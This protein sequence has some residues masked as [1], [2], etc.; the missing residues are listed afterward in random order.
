MT[1]SAQR[2][3]GLGV[4]ALV[5][6]LII[7]NLTRG[8]EWR[9]F[10]PGQLWLS[11]RRARPALL[12]AAIVGSYAN[13][14]VRA[15]RWK[16]FLEP[17]KRASLWNLFAG[18]ILGFSSIYLI[19][20][21]GELVRPGYIAR[22]EHVSFASQLAILLLERIYDTIAIVLLFGIALY[23]QPLPP[24]GAR[25]AA[26]INM[27][28]FSS[29]PTFDASKGNVQSMVLAGDVVSSSL[30][31]AQSGQTLRFRI[32]Q[33]AEGQHSFAWPANTLHAPT[34]NPGPHTETD[35]TCL[36]D[37]SRCQPVVQLR[38]LHQAAELVMI[39]ALLMVLAMVA[40]RRNSEN[41]VAS[42]D[43]RFGFLPPRIRMGLKGFL[44][45]LAQGLEAIRHWRDLA[46]SVA[47]T[48]VL[49]LINAS[50][51]WLVFRSLGGDLARISW[52]AAAI[53]IFFAGLG[54]LVQLPGVGGGFQVAIIEAL[55]RLLHVGTA[56]ATSG[57]ILMWIVTFVSAVTLAVVILL[58]EGL[59][60]TKLR[61]MGE[62]KKSEGGQ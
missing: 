38:H 40:F 57:G 20:R 56:A 32:I 5:L 29:A 28:P 48:V 31:N 26:V 8:P 59:S 50:V 44:R 39:L 14:W 12:F 53:V 7:Y 10:S 13:Y 15:L 34:V 43:R 36:Y 60:F 33:D 45:H 16:Y 49:W 17:I 54:L 23:F 52:W 61:H 27:V 21:P 6:A 41:L 62:E 30:V 42:V 19:G 4:T 9:A 37:G 51:F 2:W 11:I 55:K 24:A 25:S 58:Y 18:Q 22:K 35:W 3:L 47:W 46:A 1:K